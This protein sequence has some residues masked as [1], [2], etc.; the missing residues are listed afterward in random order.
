MRVAGIWRA[1]REGIDNP[2]QVQG[3]VL[4]FWEERNAVS[5]GERGLVQCEALVVVA[6]LDGVVVRGICP[7]E[8]LKGVA[9]HGAKCDRGDGA[10]GRRAREIRDECAGRGKIWDSFR[11]V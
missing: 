11:E 9:L 10:E 2:P 3:Q 1:V 4:G 5:N 8:S 6:L 7:A